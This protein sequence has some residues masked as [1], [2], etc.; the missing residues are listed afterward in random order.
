MARY[1]IQSNFHGKAEE[2]HFTA[3]MIVEFSDERAAEINEKLPGFITP[4]VEVEIPIT[5]T[6]NSFDKE[7]TTNDAELVSIVPTEKSKVAD[8]RD[9]LNAQGIAYDDKAKK[10][11]LLALIE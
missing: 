7:P 1:T 2:Q 9:Y 6:T 10:D 5:T 11:E 4:F 3:G 8:I